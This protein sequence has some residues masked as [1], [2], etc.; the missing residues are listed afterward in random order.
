M[1]NAAQSSRLFAHL[2]IQ[3][4]EIARFC[5]I[6]IIQRVSRRVNERETSAEH[7][8]LMGESVIFHNR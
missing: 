1:V 3:S 4:K 5:I 7:A 2:S 6:F 8:A